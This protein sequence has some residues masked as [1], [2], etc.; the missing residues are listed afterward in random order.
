MKKI[1][2]ACD[3]AGYERKLEV[4]NHLNE[5]G[6]EVVDFG[7]NC[8]DSCDYADFVHPLA[9]KIDKGEL[10]QGIIICGSA[11]GVNMTANKYQQVRSALCWVPEIAVLARSHNN[12]N[13]CAIPARFTSLEESI[14]IVNAFLSTDFEGGRHTRRVEKIAIQK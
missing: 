9:S 7:C 11:N 13:V 10:S 8:L 5:L 4:I 3:H 1:A 14:N 2:I 12:A 6:Y